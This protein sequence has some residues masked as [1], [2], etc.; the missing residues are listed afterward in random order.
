MNTLMTNCKITL[1]ILTIIMCVGASTIS[2]SQVVLSVEPAVLTEATLNES[3]VTLTLSERKFAHSIF[4]IRDAVSVSGIDGVTIPWH[5]PDKESDTEITIE[6]EFDGNIDTDAMLTFTV[7]ADAIANYNG[8]A[9]TAQL[10]VTAVEETLVASTERPLHEATLNESVVILTLS[11]RS[12]VR[13]AS[14]IKK[15]LAVNGIDGVEVERVRRISGTTVAVEL[16]FSGD[17]DVDA[18]LVFNVAA[19]GIADY[20]G[21]TLTAQLPVTAVEET[22]V[23]STERPLHEATLNESVVILTLS[24]RSFV[25]WA[26][27]I[28]KA[29][30]VNGID[31]VEVERVRRISGT[32]AAVE[33]TFSGDIDA[34]AT[35]TFAVG[36][37]AIAGYNGPTF[38][39]EV[40]VTGFQRSE[41]YILGP[42]LWM[43]AKGASIESD[44]LA[45][46]SNGDISENHVA[47]HGVNE[48][49]A[50]SVLE[51]KRGRI[52]LT[53]AMCETS[54]VSTN[55]LGLDFSAT[56]ERCSTDNINKLVNAIGLS[57]NLDLN[58]YSAYA[59]INIVSP[60]EQN[61]VLMGVGSDDTVKVWLNGEVVHKY[62][63]GTIRINGNTT[64]T[65]RSTTGIQDKFY[66]N[67]KAG[68][69]LLL[70]KVSEYTG[71]W[72]MFFE[73][74]LGDEDFTTSLPGTIPQLS[75]PA[76]PPLTE[77]NLDESVIT[78]TLNR[79]VY[80]A[81][82]AMIINAVTVA[83]ID[84]V[85]IDTTTLQRLSDQKI[86]FKLK[87]D[88]TDFEGDIALT[89]SVAAGAI[90][91][92]KGDALTA[93]TPVM[94][95]RGENLLTIYWTD[96]S[97][98]KI[99]RT[100]LDQT[101]HSN[102]DPSDIEDLVTQ[103]LES[104]RG[105]ALDVLTG[106]MY[107]TAD[108]K[109]QRANLDG[110]NVQDLVTQGLESPG[111]LALDVLTGK[112]YWTAD[113]KIQRA[114]LDGSNVQDL[115]TQGLESPGGL[116]LD[117]MA[118]KMYWT[119]DGKIQR[120]NLDGSDVQDLV[121]QGL[122]SPGGLAL[123][124]MAG[125]MYWT[126]DGKIQR[127]NLDGSDVQDLVT[128]LDTPDGIT[129][130][131]SSLVNRITEEPTITKEDVNRDGVVDVQDLAYVGLQ[132]GKTG[133]NAADVNGDGVVNVDDFVLVA[134]AVDAAAAAP[135]ARATVKSH[136]TKTQLQ[137]WLAEA[138]ASVTS[139]AHTSAY[140]RGIAV[141][142]QLLSVFTPENTILLANYPNPFNPETWIPYRLS[143]STDVTLTIYDIKGSVVRIL[144]LGHQRAGVYQKRGS[145]A[146]WDGRNAFGEKVTS[147]VYFYTLTAGDWI[148]TRKMLILK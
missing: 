85:T 15:A 82:V 18:L 66:T 108:S 62:T 23:A 20:D 69:N 47:T 147:G 113:S 131:V 96:S 88:G 107:W 70:V 80:A 119:E 5:D 35:L 27:D 118:G 72:G 79:G 86:K 93:E 57:E 99:Q 37:N 42:W 40:P 38:T 22:L 63:G 116:A 46:V 52:P 148:A 73:I 3:V 78:L 128:G 32:T 146:Y 145:A 77:A 9:L 56:V 143:K 120:A 55:V 104:P 101:I 141:I 17:I 90:K 132:Y 1:A 142:E 39:A 144:D 115:V 53:P 84:G 134:S 50:V 135:A 7:G 68:N 58:Y 33:L 106:K 49:D 129:I 126:E 138:R 123:D 136:F 109:I 100:T 19:G 61:G 60:R 83:G 122:E 4:D 65:G 98:D 102:L 21:S 87:F 51:W 25:R 89:F 8:S 92:Y 127:A 97:A 36:L 2:Y 59:L 111:G 44:Q 125:K 81:D 71:D 26:S 43:I 29:L 54:N 140:Q 94:S 67:L 16:T 95:S 10:S 48:G 11:G 34:D 41:E 105:I 114:N 76:T 6:L 121:T 130:G 91:N 28:K 137:G 117:V 75:A 13:W 110:S 112:M 24:G 64:L 12:F 45:S 74:Y 124:V 30:A 139:L 103:E 133:T 14:D 31:G